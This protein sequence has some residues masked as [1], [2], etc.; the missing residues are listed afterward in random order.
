[1][2]SKPRNTLTNY[3]EQ[4]GFLVFRIAASPDFQATVSELRQRIPSWARRFDP[5]SNEWRVKV[6]YRDVIEELFGAAPQASGRRQRRD[7]YENEGQRSQWLWILLSVAVIATVG[8]LFWSRNPDFTAE[9]QTELSATSTPYLSATP[10]VPVTTSARV[11]AQ[12]NLRGG[13]G[14]SNA[15]QRVAE[16]GEVVEPDAKAMDDDN[17]WWLRLKTGEWIRSDLVV[18]NDAGGLPYD[19]ARLPDIGEHSGEAVPATAA[20]ASQATL[21][22][23][24]EG[25]ARG[26]V[27]WIYDGDTASVRVG[28]V[29]Y[30]VRYL[31]IDS[32]EIDMPGHDEATNSN[33]D[34]VMG[35]TVELRKDVTNV[36]RYG[37]LLRYLYLEDG[38]FVNEAIVQQ[39]WATATDYPPDTAHID[40]LMNAQEEARREGLGIWEK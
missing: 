14:T 20:P 31:G 10:A 1:M 8:A 37:R 7:R 23:P 40:E 26:T 18:T 34:L 13:P 29:D 33:R 28:G 38:T 16:A 36:D 12:A 25:D 15:V 39:G 21:P 9:V 22:P 35:K 30:K 32:P 4:D 2:P 24:I 19:L 27:T 5:Q 17:F 6:E 3:R 11:N